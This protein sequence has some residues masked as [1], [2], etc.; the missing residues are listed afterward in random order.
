HDLTAPDPPL[1]VTD[2]LTRTDLHTVIREGDTLVFYT[3]GLVETPGAD[4]GD[5]LER[6]RERTEALVRAGVP[7][8]TLIRKL[9]P[10]VRDRRDDIAVIALQARS[11]P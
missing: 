1:C 6:L 11:G 8:A 3:D 9:L 10:P 7:L 5:S 4:I 2:T